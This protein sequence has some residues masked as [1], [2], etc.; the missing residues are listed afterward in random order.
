MRARMWMLRWAGVACVVGAG[1]G[2]TAVG[3]DETGPIAEGKGVAQTWCS[4]CHVVSEAQTRGSDQA[5][6][7]VSI[8]ARPEMTAE[9]LHNFLAQP[10]GKMPDFK[11]GKNDIDNVVACILSLKN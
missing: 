11:L 1:W 3:A 4:N 6:T 5:P 10:H 8:A 2:G 9:R 7:W